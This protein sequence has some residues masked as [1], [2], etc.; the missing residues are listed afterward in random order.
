MTPRHLPWFVPRPQALGSVAN[1]ALVLIL[2]LGLAA[3]SKNQS[4]TWVEEVESRDGSVFQLEGKGEIGAH[5]F[6]FARRGSIVYRSYYHRPSGAYWNAPEPLVPDVFDMVGG[7]PYVVVVLRDARLCQLLAYPDD[8][9]LAFRWSPHDGWQRV[10]VQGLPGGLHTNVLTQVFD[11]SDKSQDIQGFVSVHRK[12]QEI[13]RVSLKQL[14]EKNA[15]F[16]DK[17]GSDTDFA[18]AKATRP[19]AGFHPRPGRSR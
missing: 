9:V 10:P 6:P 7:V 13:D 1:V 16:C 3:S 4:A 5:G 8:G 15:G 12:T 11:A 17:A 14:I 2:L 19:L 18:R